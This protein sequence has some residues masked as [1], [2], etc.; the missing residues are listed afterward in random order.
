MHMPF[1]TGK[2]AYIYIP[3]IA[4]FFKTDV[5]IYI[6]RELMRFTQS[7]T[8]NFMLKRIFKLRNTFV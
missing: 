8:K 1:L 3:E 6:L 4:M 5:Y 2:I 7:K